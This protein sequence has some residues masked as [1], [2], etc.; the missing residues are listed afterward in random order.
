MIIDGKKFSPNFF[1]VKVLPTCLAPLITRGFLSEASFQ[2][3]NFSSINLLIKP[4]SYALI[5]I[6]QGYYYIFIVIIQGNNYNHPVGVFPGV[7]YRP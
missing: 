4:P 1:T 5:V 6:I 3:F 7:L 2:F